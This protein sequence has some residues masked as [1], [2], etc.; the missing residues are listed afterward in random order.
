MK[1]RLTRA[2]DSMTM[3][4]GCAHRIE[5]KLNDQLLQQKT[6]HYTKSISPVPAK[7]KGWVAAVTAVCLVLV[8]SVGGTALFLRASDY[9]LT[10][11]RET[12]LPFTAE[13]NTTTP[14]DHYSVATSL[15]AAEVEAF[16]KIVRNNVL[17]ENWDALADKV[18]YP[19]TIQDQEIQEEQKFLEWM[20]IFSLNPSFAEALSNETCAA[21]FCNWQGICMG[22]GQIWINEVGGK[23]K[24]TSFGVEIQEEPAEEDQTKQMP[25]IF[26]DIL[27]GKPVSFTGRH[28]LLTAE[29]WCTGLW[30]DV[31][32]DAFA[33]VD[34]DG[35]NVC[36]AVL[37]VQ[38]PEGKDYGFLVLR[39]EGQEVCAYSFR[40]GELYDLKKDGSFNRSDNIS[41]SKTFRLS[42][43][44][45]GACCSTSED[46]GEQDLP[47]VDWHVYP[48]ESAELVLQ[49]YE[50]VTG[51]GWS[52]LPS[53]P[54]YYFE[55]L[56]EKAMVN[57]WNVLKEQM[58]RE[59]KNCVEDNGTVAV[60]DPDAPGTALY[61]TLTG[62]N[63]YQQFETLGFYICTEE[64]EYQAEVRDMLS[65]DPQY[66]IDVMDPEL[67][68]PVQRPEFL[69]SYFGWTISPDAGDLSEKETVRTLTEEFSA[70]LLA[71]DTEAMEHYLAEDFQK[72][73]K[74]PDPVEA[75]ILA[76]RDLP[77]QAAQTGEKCNVT[78]TL[79]E[80]GTN[81]Y[82]SINL[83]LVK[84]KNGWKVQFYSL[85]E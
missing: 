19:L 34:M 70:L 16:A 48:C 65:D 85:W 7:G 20:E 25:E 49:S 74:D 10:A 14:V 9:M 39:Q 15:S 42:F 18:S 53:G 22:D 17:T 37:R 24:V 61:G 38:T 1:R 54:Y 36:E 30:G 29:Q 11:H 45:N 71:G 23:L 66:V 80:S 26:A 40:Y 59:E 77:E 73:G 63:G 46:A 55:L 5:Q 81:R 33:V 76:I 8:L 43:E 44:G 21:M 31:T 47:V 64:R 41:N 82:F 32:V 79:G 62:E 12:V 84:Q 13:E 58:I 69:V 72:N 35:D 28:E 6:G 27:S 50:Y 75:E 4:D 56:A 52:L 57:D 60:F 78:V 68:C 2:Y 67:E 3:P 51:T 83:T